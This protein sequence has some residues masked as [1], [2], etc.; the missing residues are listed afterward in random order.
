MAPEE[1]EFLEQQIGQIDQEMANL[2]RPHED[3][4][5]RL[6][7][8]PGLGVDSAQQMIAEVGP[9]VATFPSAKQ[10][11]WWVGACPGDD[12]RRA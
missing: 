9:T 6:A 10:L 8:V 2:L 7:Q 3:A 11:S 1:L 4:V 12:E 5:Q